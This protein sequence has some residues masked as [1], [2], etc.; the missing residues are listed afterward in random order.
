MRGSFYAKIHSGTMHNRGRG[1]SRQARWIDARDIPLQYLREDYGLPRDAAKHPHN[2]E[3][4]VW[5]IDNCGWRIAKH[6]V[7]HSVIVDTVSYDPD[8]PRIYFK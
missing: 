1:V 5:D 6:A 4:L 7:S 2:I 8:D 3:S